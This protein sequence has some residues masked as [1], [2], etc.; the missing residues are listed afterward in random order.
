M[1]IG[2]NFRTENKTQWLTNNEYSQFEVDESQFEVEK[3]LI[4]R[5]NKRRIMPTPLI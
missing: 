3:L 1:Q 2:I 5:S 4:V